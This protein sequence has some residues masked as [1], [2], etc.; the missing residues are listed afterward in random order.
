MSKLTTIIKQEFKMT[1][2]NKAFV[3]MTILGPFLIAAISILPGTL[4]QRQGEVAENTVIAFV[5]G[6][7]ALFDQMSQSLVGTRLVPERF[8][9]DESARRAV[10]DGDVS[11][12]FV[13][14]DEYLASP[15]VEYFSRTGTDMQI[16]TILETTLGAVVVGRRVADA[17]L[18]PAQ[19]AALTHRPSVVMRR[20]ET[21]G[22]GVEQDFFSVI[23]TA[24]TF[25]MLIYMTVLL[26]GQMIGRSV[27]TEK[28]SNTVEIMLS[29]V[30]PTEMLFGKI[31]GKGFAAMLQYAIWIGVALLIVTIVGPAIGVEVPVNISPANLGYLFVFFTLAFFLYASAYAAIGSGAEDEQH[32]GQLSMPLIVFL[33]IP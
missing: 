17:G 13:V 29:S 10:L 25:V 7:D 5:G 26:Y 21:T 18:D 27:L 11:G 15:T 33:I 3:V 23:L 32:L 9:D 2:A 8:A 12:A 20:L 19:V 24:I 14:P 4:A 6:S 16:A 22:E 31:L 28:T 1:A 30:R